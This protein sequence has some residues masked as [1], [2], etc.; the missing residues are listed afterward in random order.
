M[1]HKRTD[2]VWHNHRGAKVPREYVPDLD[3]KKETV[4]GKIYNKAEKLSERLAAFKEEAFNEVDEIY[5]EE[6]K[7]AEIDPSER[8]GN[9]TLTSFDKSVKIEINVSDRIEFDENIEFAQ[10]KFREFIALKTKGTDQELAELVNQAFSTRK[11]KLDT[12]RVL[13]LFSYKITHPVWL[14]GLEFVKKSMS[15][16]SSVRYMEISAKDKN[17]DY[18]AVKLNFSSI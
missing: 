14:Q 9:Y 3:K 2:K 11:G 8:K 7:R 5:E 12:K 6:L 17:G 1:L 4:V 13:S 15:T 16:N 10:V 18:K